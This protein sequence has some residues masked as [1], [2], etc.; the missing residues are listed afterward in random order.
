MKMAVGAV[1]L[2]AVGYVVRTFLRRRQPDEPDF[3][4]LPVQPQPSHIMEAATKELTPQ[5][6]ERAAQREAIAKLAKSKPD[7]VA[8]LVKAWINED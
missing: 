4:E 7:E 3:M 8:Q 6:K 5:E 1:A 2:L